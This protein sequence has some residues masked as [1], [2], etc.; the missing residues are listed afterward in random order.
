MAGPSGK[1]VLNRERFDAVLFD[2][3][4][5][6]T[7]TARVHA[8]AWKRMFDD[9]LREHASERGGDVSPFDV[10]TDYLQYVDGKPR[11]EG[12]RGFL[13]SR[14][15]RLPEGRV[16]DP[17]DRPT[18]RGLGNRKN[19]LLKAVIDSDGVEVYEGSLALVRRL[20]QEGF[21]TAIV[22]SSRNCARVLAAA[23]IADLFDVR[24][25]GEVAADR[26][27]AG[28]PAPDTF[29]AA[30]EQLGVAPE[31]SVV[32][33][34]AISGVRAGRAGD[35]GLVIGVAREGNAEVLAEN[36]ADLVVADLAE[37]DP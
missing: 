27:L 1:A 29:L 22:S 8:V 3:D 37:M 16:D 21:K 20:R 31:R 17:P 36:G 18:V 33:E 23:G 32:V 4:G 25:D 13:E 5:V 11:S 30:A 28:K 10:E 14:E 9:F 35:F 24:V 12:V 7:D 19:E 2:L 26:H 15:I 34:D 6:I